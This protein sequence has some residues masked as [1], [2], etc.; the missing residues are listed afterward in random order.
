MARTARIAIIGGASADSPPRTRCAAAASR[1]RFTRPSRAEGDRR[2]RRAR[3]QR[4]EGAACARPRG[5]GTGDRLGSRGPHPAQLED[6]RAIMATSNATQASR[7]G[8]RLLRP[9]R[10]SARRARPRAARRDHH[11][12]RP[13]RLGRRWRRGRLRTLHGRQRDRG[14]RRHRRRRHPL[15]GASIAVRRD[16]PRFTGKICYRSVIGIDA[17]PGGPPA[18]ESVTWL[19]P[20]GAIVVYRLRRGEL[21]N[22]V[23]HYETRPSSTSPGSPSAT[24]P[25]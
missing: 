20:H 11:P 19:G 21:I 9:P 18:P 6:R 12:R 8:R 16:A 22:V 3:A 24:A 2:R 17:V 23:S 1:C 7:Y 10:R 15:H 13:L 4:D 25:R 14:R 5:A